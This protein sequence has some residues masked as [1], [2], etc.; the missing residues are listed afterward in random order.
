METAYVNVYKSQ[1]K[2]KSNY[3]KLH[4]DPPKY[5]IG[6]KVLLL[7]DGIQL[8]P[9]VNQSAK[10]LQPYIGLFNITQVSQGGL[11]VHLK[12][13]LTMKCH[14]VF[15]VSKVKPWIDPCSKFPSHKASWD[16][17]PLVISEDGD[18]FEV[19]KILDD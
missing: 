14:N 12:L 1:Q 9:S 6:D 11:N 13:P 19:E 8:A 4:D 5:V 17:P 16:P 7:H 18:E 3:D 2:M 15:H 10:L